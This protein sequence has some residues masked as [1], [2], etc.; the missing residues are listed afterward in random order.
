MRLQGIAMAAAVGL[1]LPATATALEAPPA[2]DASGVVVGAKDN[3]LSRCDERGLIRYVRAYEAGL[4]VGRNIVDDGVAGTG[5]APSTARACAWSARLSLLLNPPEPVLAEAS[6]S[7][8][9]SALTEPSYESTGSEWDSV[10]EC[11]SGGD[12]SAN[13]GNGYY[14]GL[15]FDSETWDAYGNPACAEASDCS[16]AEQAA[17][18]EAVPYDAWPNC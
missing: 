6:A 5:E 11:E 7:S 13:T 3:G 14:G 17:A 2:K 4:D 1:L 9:E 8:A 16:A 18:A 10:A 12:W 15:Q